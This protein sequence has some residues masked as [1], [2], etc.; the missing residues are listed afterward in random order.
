MT[1]TAS[2]NHQPPANV[3]DHL[4]VAVYTCDRVGY[5]T[6]YNN[7]AVKLWGKD[8]WCGSW[9][10]YKPN[11]EPLPLDTC[12]MARVLKDGIPITGEYIIIERPDG[13]RV[14]VHPYPVA[15]FDDNG[16]ITGAV[17]TLIDVTAI[18]QEEE[19]QAVLAAIID[20]SDDTI[21]SKTLQGVI[22]SWNKAAERMFGYTEEEVVGKHI[23]LI[24]PPERINE[25]SLIIGQIAQGNRVEHFE[26]Y[27][28][29]KNGIQIPISLS[30]SP[31]KNFQGHVIGASKIA[32]NITDRITA[33]E[34]QA[35]LAAIIDTSDDTIISK[36]LQGIITSWNPAAERM[37]GYTGDEVI[38][39]HIS[40]LIPPDRINEED[41]IIGQIARGNKVDHFQ[42]IRRAKDGRLIPISLSVS[43]IKD[44]RGTVIGASKIARDISLQKAAHDSAV[45]YAQS[46]ETINSTIKTITEELDLNNILQKVTDTTTALTG[47]AFGAFFYNQVDAAGE[48]FMLYTLSGAPI[49]AFERFG[50]P[51]NTDVFHATFSG[52]GIVRVDDITK[53]PR[54]GNNHPHYGMPAGH[55]PLV[56]Y[57]AVPV[58][59]RT[60]T[61]IGGLFFGHPDAGVFT[62]EHEVIVSAIASQA[63]ISL[64]NAKLYEQVKA[65]NEK[66][67]EFIGLASHELK[68]PLTSISGYLQ[69]LNRMQTDEKSKRFVSKTLQQVNKLSA[70]VS[71]LLDVSKIHAGKLQLSKKEFDISRVVNDVIELIE[72][73]NTTHTISLQSSAT[74]LHIF[75]DPQ[76]I[77]QVLINLLTNAIKYSPSGEK[78]LVS[79]IQTDSQVRISVQ[80]FG[81]GIP[82]DQL[83]QIFTRFHRVDDVSPNIS[84]LGIGL[85]ICSEII[86]RHNGKIWAESQTGKGSTFWISL[87]LYDHS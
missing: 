30:V 70:L 77:E 79:L 83:K 9:K 43:P 7:A 55:L 67:D 85:Y 51:R 45:R 73:S 46:L 39:K 48:S 13:I 69:I 59:S 32:R 1:L 71:D 24:I 42:T 62:E 50:M 21:I 80:D 68:T 36:T 16:E 47:A 33:D 49:S 41:E 61:V 37:F 82:E 6:S 40:I 25:E 28:V 18:T 17:N 38:G 2:N 44:N 20:T 56:S 74:G 19:K 31:V 14:K 65:L 5:I 57:L 23:S 64:D 81:F 22:T 58:I 12:P 29:G 60:G 76:R 34:K 15:V 35:V 4:P 78:V 87:P 10:I 3:Y 63:A 66:K 27:R 72:H 54:Y 84:G 8:L 53:D 52:E 11:G 26:T 75:A 86:E